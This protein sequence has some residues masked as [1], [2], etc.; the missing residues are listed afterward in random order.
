LPS[1]A[2]LAKDIAV[3]EIAFGEF[4]HGCVADRADLQTS[5]I[6]A[7]E[8]RCRR[9]CARSDCIDQRHSKAEEFRHR[10]QL[11]ERRPL[12]AERVNVAADYVRKKP[13]GQHR[14]SR[15][16]AERAAAVSDVENDPTPPRFEHFLSDPPVLPYRRIGKRAKTVRQDISAAQTRK[17]FEPA[18]WRVVEMRHDR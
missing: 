4:Q 1:C 12:D 14:L 9:G 7:A 3:F 6:A 15:A 13:S 16:K 2:N 8:R 17:H 11:V 5:D 10:H 18:R